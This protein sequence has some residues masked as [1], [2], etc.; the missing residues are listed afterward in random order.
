M[1]WGGEVTKQMKLETAPA[2]AASITIYPT[3]PD[4]LQYNLNFIIVY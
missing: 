1:S 4:H 3:H 2:G